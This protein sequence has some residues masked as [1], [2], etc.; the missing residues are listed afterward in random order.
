MNIASTMPPDDRM[1][2]FDA[3]GRMTEWQETSA[4]LGDSRHQQGE[5]LT[6]D[7]DGRAAKRLRRNRIWAYPANGLLTN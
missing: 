3:A 6:F 5:T 7:G 1:W 4:Y 2:K